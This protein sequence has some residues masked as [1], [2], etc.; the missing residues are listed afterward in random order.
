MGG[1]GGLRL[2]ISSAQL[3]IMFI[4]DVIDTK[5]LLQCLQYHLLTLI[6]CKGM[7]V[8]PPTKGHLVTR[9]FVLYR[10]V[11]FIWRLKCTGSYN[12][13]WDG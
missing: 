1:G 4:E 10:E 9:S 6:V 8:V 13:N 11:S 5:R 12:R 7:A 2:G 3:Y